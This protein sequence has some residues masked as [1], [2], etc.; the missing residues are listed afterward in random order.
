MHFAALHE[1]GRICSHGVP[2]RSVTCSSACL[3]ATRSP[4]AR[5]HFVQGSLLNLRTWRPAPCRQ[6]STSFMSPGQIL[7][8]LRRNSFKPRSLYPLC[9]ASAAGDQMPSE[10]PCSMTSAKAWTR[11]GTWSAKMASLPKTTSKSLCEKS[12]ERFWKQM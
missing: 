2:H 1:A 4:S 11:H 7:S 12:V 10:L 6:V 9:R 8:R 3:H 5:C